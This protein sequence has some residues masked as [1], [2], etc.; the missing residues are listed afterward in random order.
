MTTPPL[1]LNLPENSATYGLSR[2]SYSVAA[3]AALLWDY[4][5]QS[6]IHRTL[7]NSGMQ[8]LEQIAINK[9]RA[10]IT[11]LEEMHRVLIVGS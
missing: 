6:D 8:T 7:V 4:A 9:V 5:T 10:G 1:K 3:I 2:N 11:T